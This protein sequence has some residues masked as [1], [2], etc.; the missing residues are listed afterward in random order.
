MKVTD[1]ARDPEICVVS[2]KI[3][4]S[5]GN[6]VRA[7]IEYLTQPAFCLRTKR[8]GGVRH[9]I[10]PDKSSVVTVQRMVRAGISV[11]L[12]TSLSW[13]WKVISSSQSAFAT[14]FLSTPANTDLPAKW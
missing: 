12:P 8:N 5:T 14:L 1:A 6:A 13:R 10:K 7:V 11:Q 9:R 4:G 2:A 3:D